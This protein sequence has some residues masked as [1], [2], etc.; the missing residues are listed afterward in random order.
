MKEGACHSLTKT[1]DNMRVVRGN[2]HFQD[3]SV[4]CKWVN[5]HEQNVMRT[6]KEIYGEKSEGII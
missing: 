5:G 2:G 4:T 6:G 1:E 3:P